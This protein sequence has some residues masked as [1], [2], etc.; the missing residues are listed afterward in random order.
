VAVADTIGIAAIAL[1]SGAVAAALY[2]MRAVSQPWM[3]WL[4]A[5]PFLVGGCLWVW[6]ISK[7]TRD[8]GSDKWGYALIFTPLIGA[9]SF[10]VDVFVGSSNGHYKTFLEAASHAGSPIGFPL[11]VLICPIGTLVAFGSWIRRIT[12]RDF[13]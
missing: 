1:A 9:I 3:V 5:F 7:E 13:V 2:G 8:W 4:I 11:T 12:L 6:H 10:A